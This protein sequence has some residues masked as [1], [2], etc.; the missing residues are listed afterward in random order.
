[1]VNDVQ[2]NKFNA[3]MNYTFWNERM[4]AGY[5]KLFCFI[6]EVVLLFDN[7]VSLFFIDIRIGKVMQESV[8]TFK[9]GN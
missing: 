3:G 5:V 4:I 8:W 1:M 6:E 2:Q 7:G 9:Y